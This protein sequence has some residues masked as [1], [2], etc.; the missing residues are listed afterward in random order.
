MKVRLDEFPLDWFVHSA[1][2]VM[3]SFLWNGMTDGTALDL[4]ADPVRN[5]AWQNL[6][7]SHKDMEHL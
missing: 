6:L 2:F 5:S 7:L 4:A 1:R 3:M